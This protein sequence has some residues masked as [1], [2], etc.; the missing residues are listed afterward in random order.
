MEIMNFWLLKSGQTV[1]QLDIFMLKHLLVAELGAI[2]MIMIGVL[3]TTL[4]T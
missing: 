2:V 3:Y 4:D 1:L